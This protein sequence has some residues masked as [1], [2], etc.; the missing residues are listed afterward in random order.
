MEDLSKFEKFN[1]ESLDL[2]LK[3]IFN[4]KFIYNSDQQ[5][6]LAKKWFEFLIQKKF[7]FNLILKINFD[8]NSP[9]IYD[10]NHNKFSIDFVNDHRNYNKK[11]MG[12]RNEIIS[13]AMGAGRHGHKILDLS[14][15]LGI[16]SVFLYQLGYQVLG[17]ERHPLI[18]IS[19]RTA[20]ENYY[21]NFLKINEDP[22]N[23][24]IDDMKLDFRFISAA[25]F[26][27]LN[28]DTECTDFNIIYFDPMFPE[29]IKSALPRQE[30]VFFR[31]LVGADLDA[32]FIIENYIELVKSQKNQIQKRIVIKR[33]IKAPLLIKQKPE[34][35]FFG[36]LIRFD[37]YGVK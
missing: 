34:S 33:P 25:D 21:I 27:N 28:N 10:L 12:L 24:L 32:S 6:L 20:L 23:Q 14:A 26:L 35:Q 18:Y 3:N 7:N 36:K 19:L 17:L 9:V 11:K 15:G 4:E 1:F 5:Q 37:I 22:K 2:K 30:M 8:S 13:K 31:N 16:D 29:K